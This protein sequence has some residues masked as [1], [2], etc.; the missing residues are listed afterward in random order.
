MELSG[1]LTSNADLNPEKGSNS[2]HWIRLGGTHVHSE[3][4]VK[5]KIPMT[6]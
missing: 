3:R 2:I 6:I 1:Q 4:M 5:I